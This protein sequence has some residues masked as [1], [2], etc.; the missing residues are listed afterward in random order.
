MLRNIKVVLGIEESQ[1]FSESLKSSHMELVAELAIELIKLAFASVDTTLEVDESEPF[2]LRDTSTASHL[3]PGG[4]YEA[5]GGGLK[6]GGADIPRDVDWRSN[7]F[8]CAR[9][10]RSRIKR[11]CKS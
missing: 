11:A 5:I 8:S 2:V 6:P 1:L 10:A 7:A 9:I 4:A 3:L